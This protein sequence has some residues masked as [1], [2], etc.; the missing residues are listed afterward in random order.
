MARITGITQGPPDLIIPGDGENFR[1][2][3]GFPMQVG[4]TQAALLCN[5]RTEQMPTG[6]FENGVDVVLFDEIDSISSATPTPIVRNERYVAP[7]GSRRLV[8]KYP[9]VGGFVPLG[10][11]GADGRPHPHAGTGFGV[12]DDLDFPML[13]DGSYSKSD[14]TGTMIRRTVLH[15]F[16]YDGSHFHAHQTSTDEPLKVPDSPWH[17]YSN[18]LHTAIADGDDLLYP[19][20][21][22]TDDPALCYPTPNAAGVSRWKFADGQWQLSQFVPIAHSRQAPVPRMLYG[23]A[24]ELTASEPSLI[25]DVDGSLLFTARLSGDDVEDHVVRVWQSRDA[26][27]T[28]SLVIDQHQGRGQAP[29]TINSASDGT[30]YLA[31]N[32]TG[33]E[34]DQLC[35]LPLN[36]QRTGLLE[37]VC[38]RDALVEF[39]PPPTGPVWFMDHPNAITLRLADGDWHNVLVY[40]LMDRGEHAGAAPPAETG[41]YVEEVTCC[42][43]AIPLWS[44]A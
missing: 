25:R 29:I 9:I 43:P 30:P 31:T 44:F 3:L 34:R 22:T 26:G 38:I 16:S 27:E 37:P 35:L 33:R 24:V 4:P 13:D 39:G 20:C 23:R 42:E 6:D 8:I 40:R 10:A 32:P 12:N 36:P 41:L 11:L 2:G 21:G 5:L 1:Y 14:K 7:D 17:L 18:G 15:Q 28:W 19:A